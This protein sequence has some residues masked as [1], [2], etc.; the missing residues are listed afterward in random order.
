MLVE[1]WKSVLW[2]SWTIWAAAAG[3]ALPELAQFAADHTDALPLTPEWKNY[4]RLASLALVIVVRPLH[5]ASLHE[6]AAP[7]SPLLKE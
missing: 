2:R 1:N 7:P 4:I 5:Q 6:P 3:L